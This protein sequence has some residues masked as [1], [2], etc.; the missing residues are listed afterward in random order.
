MSFYSI[1]NIVCE[2]PSLFG[3]GLSCIVLVGVTIKLRPRSFYLVG[4]FQNNGPVNLSAQVQGVNKHAGWFRT[5]P[6]LVS[7][8]TRLFELTVN[9]KRYGRNDKLAERCSLS[10]TP[11]VSWRQVRRFRD[12]TLRK[13]SRSVRLLS[14]KHTK[15]KRTC[16][17]KH[18]LLSVGRDAEEI[19]NSRTNR[20]YNLPNASCA[21]GHASVN[22]RRRLSS[23]D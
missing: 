9:M 5:L 4:V 7:C 18:R 21:N 10:L 19:I 15:C 20:K 6:L 1:L 12:Y 3:E 22:I 8:F 16:R 13:R 17:E 14:Y 23:T 2:V 11:S